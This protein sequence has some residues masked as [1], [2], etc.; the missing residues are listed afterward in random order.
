MSEYENKSID[1]GQ[2]LGW[3]DEI[4]KESEFELL[5]PGTYD[6]VV[7]S[8]ERGRHEKSDNMAACN[9]ANLRLHVSDPVSGKSGSVFDKLFLNTKMEWKLSQFFTSIGQKKKGEPLR[10]NWTMVPGSS[11][12]LEIEISRYQDDYGNLKEN[13]KVKRYIPKDEPKAFTPGAF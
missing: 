10:P 5:P 11:G 12:K 13:N 7:E 1:I 8:M 2:E 3:D 6:F 9:V 4:S